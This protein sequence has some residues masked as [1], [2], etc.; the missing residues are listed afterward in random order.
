MLWAPVLVRVTTGAA[1]LE[2]APRRGARPARW[3]L[4]PPNCRVVAGLELERQELKD[5]HEACGGCR[6]RVMKRLRRLGLGGRGRRRGRLA[7]RPLALGCRCHRRNQ[8]PPS[9]P[10]PPSPSPPLPPPVW[11]RH[12]R[13]RCC[14]R[15]RLCA[16]SVRRLPPDP[17]LVLPLV[18]LETG[19]PE[20]ELVLE[21]VPLVPVVTGAAVAVPVVLPLEAVLT[22]GAEVGGGARG[23]R[24]CA[25]CGRTAF[26]GG[27][28]APPGAS[29]S[30]AW[31]DGSPSCGPS[32]SGPQL[33]WWSPGL[34]V[35][36][37]A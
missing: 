20:P 13:R 11:V 5:D 18:P 21:L 1:V 19:V 9:P 27:P 28:I 26:F 2:A 36:L 16:L 4:A 32:A 31:C 35:E 23:S 6:E 22:G 29:A 12:H 25:R 3:G 17:E 24:R 34:R 30:R 15:R 33:S 10:S 14:H 7:G 37:A 8:S